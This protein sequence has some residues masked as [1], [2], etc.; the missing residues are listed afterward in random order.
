VSAHVERFEFAVYEP[1][2]TV[3][4]GR[5]LF[6]QFGSPGRNLN[7]A[8]KTGN[9][10][11]FWF[12]LGID[13]PSNTPSERWLLPDAVGCQFMSIRSPFWYRVCCYPRIG[14]ARLALPDSNIDLRRL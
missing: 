8:E 1:S 9:L 11:S 2:V 5:N 4:S 14:P 6:L 12:R 10:L 3:G 13:T 7:H